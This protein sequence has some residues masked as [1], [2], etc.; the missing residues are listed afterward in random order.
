MQTTL[1]R[2]AI[3]AAATA[4]ALPVLA[5][6][7]G[8][9]RAAATTAAPATGAAT[10]APA[11][12]TSAAGAATTASS[13]GTASASDPCSLLTDA[14]V[15][16]LAPA[17][18]HGKVHKVGGA[19]ICEW[20]DA[21]GIPFVQFQVYQAPASS[22]RAE[23]KNTIGAYGGYRIIDVAGLGDEAAAAFQKADPAKG[24]SPGLAALTVRTGDRVLEL[25]TPR[26]DVRQS[27]PAFALVETLAAKAL[28]RLK[29]GR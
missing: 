26:V 6:C 17:A 5:G 19:R 11:V 16:R 9:T 22:L 29:A 13:G 28:V 23:L 15:K 27:S 8:G 14:E 1:N 25:A 10:T 3:A 20:L 21:N 24:L 7:G 18:R 12:T 4:I 2:L